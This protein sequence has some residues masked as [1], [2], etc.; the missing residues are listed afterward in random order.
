L[1]PFRIPWP[2]PQDSEGADDGGIQGIT[3]RKTAERR[4]DE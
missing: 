4:A 3:N 2:I 1:A